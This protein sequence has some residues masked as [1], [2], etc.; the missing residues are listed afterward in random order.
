MDSQSIESETTFADWCK[1]RPV[2]QT[3]TKEL[4][5]GGLE[6]LAPVGPDAEGGLASSD[7]VKSVIFNRSGSI[8]SS[9]CIIKVDLFLG[10]QKQSLPDRVDGAANY[11]Q[12]PL[13]L[14]DDDR[15][16][17]YGTGMPT[18]AGLRNALERM[19]AARGGP[20]RIVWTSL[21]EEPVLY[22]KGRPHVLRLVDAPI[23]NIESTGIDA[24]VVESMESALQRDIMDEMQRNGRILLHDEVEI[25]AGHFD[26]APIWDKVSEN[27]LQTPKQLYEQVVSEGYQVRYNRIAIT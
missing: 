7:E 13:V 10:L 14:D 16:F 25:S 12:V 23:K 9:G 5:E 3:F 26:L 2:L 11:R 24:T 20:K 17:V 22:I 1:E 6:V 4:H 8:L 27:D 21:R 19:G 18:C 15:S